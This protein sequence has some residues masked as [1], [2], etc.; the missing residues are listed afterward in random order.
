MGLKLHHLLVWFL[1]F[2]AFFSCG[3]AFRISRADHATS[4]TSYVNSTH[5]TNLKDPRLI[6]FVSIPFL[7]HLNPL[8]NIAREMKDRGH[9]VLIATMDAPRFQHIKNELPFHPL[10]LLNN[11]ITEKEEQKLKKST[12]EISQN[13][14]LQ[15]M[16]RWSF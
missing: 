14:N 5:E 7:G 3:C 10:G 11:T 2:I 13:F 12:A 4:S 1:L 8:V 6:L 15:G 9:N 16:Q